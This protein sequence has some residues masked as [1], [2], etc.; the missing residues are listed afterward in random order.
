MYTHSRAHQK[1]SI[2]QQKKTTVTNANTLTRNT[3]S[4]KC[5]RLQQPTADEKSMR[6]ANQKT[7]FVYRFKTLIKYFSRRF[8][9]SLRTHNLCAQNTFS[10]F[11]SLSLTLGPFEHVLCSEFTS[12]RASFRC[13]HNPRSQ[14]NCR[15]LNFCCSSVSFRSVNKQ[16]QQQQQSTEKWKQ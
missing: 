12:V 3:F 1:A 7:K 14:M 10:L 2:Q 15:I 8:N 5:C 9:Y 6:S 13:L 4:S 16:L 11:S